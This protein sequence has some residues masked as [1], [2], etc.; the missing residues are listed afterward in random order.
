VA[1]EIADHLHVLFSKTDPTPE[2][3]LALKAKVTGMSFEQLAPDAKTD[4]A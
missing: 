1:P 2:D 3:W 4:Q